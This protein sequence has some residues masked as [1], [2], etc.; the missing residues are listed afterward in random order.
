[1]DRVPLAERPLFSIVTVCWNAERS[2][3]GTI[4][5]VLHQDP[6]GS[7]VE[8]IVVDGAST[9][10]TLNVLAAYPHLRVLSERD[11]GIYDAM[12]KGV[13]LATGKYIGILNA[14]DWYEPDALRSVAEALRSSPESE[15]VHGDIRRWR[16]EISLDVVRPP[17]GKG[18]W[19]SVLMPVNHPACFV[20]KD[21]FD[22][23]GGFDTSY[24]IFADFE[25]VKRV[26]NGGARL[27]YC[28]KV[29]TNFRVGGVSTMRFAVAERYR[30]YRS[31]GAGTLSTSAAI[32]YSCA[33]IL[34]NRLSLF[35]PR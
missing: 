32:A 14:D 26:I 11:A 25:W 9:D 20:S 22:R 18:F 31:S 19:T 2:I 15:F 1:M 17:L 35:T 16:G 4:E 8:H 12:N 23:F 3:K 5:S 34:R 6:F 29:L 27:L 21:L 28:P 24:R 10:G 33:A 7:T 30:V 13:A